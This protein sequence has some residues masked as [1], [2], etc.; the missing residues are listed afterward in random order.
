[1]HHT[2]C[3]QPGVRAGPGPDPS[4]HRLLWPSSPRPSCWLLPPLAPPPCGP[5]REGGREGWRDGG[6][7]GWREREIEG[8]GEREGKKEVGAR[9][10][11]ETLLHSP[12]PLA[13]LTQIIPH[14]PPFIFL[15]PFSFIYLIF[16][17]LS[18]LSVCLSICLFVR[19]FVCLSVVCL[20][21]SL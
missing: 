13:L 17:P 1:M 11:K 8:E 20:S 15:L 3:W 14:F 4:E 7:E 19:L 18:S 12:I 6:V 5:E 16:P 10:D 21:V 9:E 2:P